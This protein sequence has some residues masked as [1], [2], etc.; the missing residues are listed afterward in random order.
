[1]TDAN[2]DQPVTRAD[3]DAP[4]FAANGVRLSAREW[5]IAAVIVLLV[6]LGVPE[7]WDRMESFDPQADY[8]VPFDSSEDYWTYKRLVARAVEDERI[9]LIGD[10]V[11]WGEYVEPQQ[12]LSHFLNQAD[13]STHFANGG[14]NGTHPLALAGLVRDYAAEIT[15]TKVI[16]HCNLLW[17]SSV[18]RDLQTEKELSFNHPQLVPQF[19][20]Q[21][22]CYKA[23]VEERIGIVVD[24][25]LPFRTWVHHLRIA[26]FDNLDVP[27]WTTEHP[28]ENPFVR[29]NMALPQPENRPHSRPISWTKRGIQRQDMPWIE[30]DTSLQWRAFQATVHRLQSRGNRVFVIVGPFNEH[31][32]TAASRKRYQELRHQVEVWLRGTLT[33]YLLATPLPS[34]EYGDASH[35][36]SAGYAR[37]AE[38][39]YAN[40]AFQQWL[41]SP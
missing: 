35:P 24:R 2:C 11:I 3:D 19:I 12:T 6:V 15:G 27:S 37:L 40:D 23:P 14:V 22:P 33:P 41:N 29:I 36:L 32:L 5:C 1:M 38:Q 17:M 13:R 30:Q 18:E 8:R 9:L 21:I 16:L 20:P 39:I 4:S 28:Y 34:D 7:I 10:S 25:T 26:S 31:M